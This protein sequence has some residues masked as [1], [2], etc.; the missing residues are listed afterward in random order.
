MRW[1]I[2]AFAVASFP[3]TA[4]EA[5]PITPIAAALKVSFEREFKV[6]GCGAGNADCKLTALALPTPRKPEP[7]TCLKSILPDVVYER[8]GHGALG[9]EFTISAS[10]A[11]GTDAN[12]ASEKLGDFVA[13][14]VTEND[15]LQDFCFPRSLKIG[16]E[17]IKLRLRDAPSRS[18]IIGGML[19]GVYMGMLAN[20][21]KGAIVGAA[22]AGAAAGVGFR[23]LPES[24][25]TSLLGETSTGVVYVSVLSTKPKQLVKVG[26]RVIGETAIPKFGMPKASLKKLTIGQSA[27][28]VMSKA[29]AA[30]SAGI[31]YQFR[32]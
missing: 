26:N 16:G 11:K 29:C 21:S 25:V 18:Q 12:P 31:E 32:C 28:H 17:T 20:K 30:F 4:Q 19:G 3:A 8:E 24:M 22:I 7:E 5:T 9:V 6:V 13:V 2:L 27:T 15:G 14:M 10:L 23:E 1:S